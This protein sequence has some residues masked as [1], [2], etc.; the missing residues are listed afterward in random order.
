VFLL[1]TNACIHLLNGTSPALA[2][3]LQSYHPSELR[4]CSVVKAELLY[5]ARK[6]RRVAENLE[7]LRRFF[8]PFVSLPF[9]DRCSEQYGAIRAQLEALGTPIG[10]ND[11][12]IAATARAHDL[13]L[14]THNVEEFSRVVG[15]PV[16]DWESDS[17]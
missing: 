9:D 11:L 13:T 10:P 15:L 3:R 12:I 5:G 7:A 14:I 16:Q 1:D 17:F 2:S 6:S 4:L 8:E